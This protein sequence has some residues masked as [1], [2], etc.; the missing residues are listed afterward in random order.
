MGGL[1]VRAAVAHAL[2]HESLVYF[3]DGAN[4]PYGPRPRHEIIQFVDEAIRRLIEE[5]DVKMVVVACNAAT[6][7]AIDHLRTK[8]AGRN[9]P[10]VGMEPAV[11]PAALT[12]RTGT[13]GVLATAAAFRGPLY[14]A[15]SEKYRGKINILET[16]GE[17]FVELVETDREN[18]PEALETVR[19]ALEPM[20]A[21]EADRI[22]L[23]CTH[24]PFLAPQIRRVIDRWWER[25]RYENENDKAET[26]SKKP[27]IVDSAP[28]IARRTG[29]LLMENNMQADPG[30]HSSSHLFLSFAGEDYLTHLARKSEKVPLI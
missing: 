13:I 15:T 10:I 22:V 16:V 26:T 24:Y 17:G 21:A 25:R 14:R 6:G 8:Y 18:T 29:Q 20:L 4:V 2:P 3:G 5:H 23:G 12:T 7:A 28:A 1:T 11:K 9:I 19:R 30:R 27:L